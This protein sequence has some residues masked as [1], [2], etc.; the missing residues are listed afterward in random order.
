M[1]EPTKNLDE[2]V[3]K[4]WIPVEGLGL[5]EPSSVLRRRGVK[6]SQEGSRALSCLGVLLIVAAAF[7]S[8]VSVGTEVLAFKIL[9]IL[10]AGGAGLSLCLY[11]RLAEK[12][13][14]VDM[15]ERS[16]RFKGGA[17]V[18][19]DSVIGLQVCSKSFNPPLNANVENAILI[20]LAYQLNIAYLNADGAIERR[21]L[22]ADP[23]L[24]L[25]MDLAAGY[26]RLCSIRTLG[27]ESL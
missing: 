15:A 20:S 25:V 3:P 19:L 4:Y 11:R 22:L 7:I 1:T 26:R 14:L 21:C 13:V 27:Q 24:N 18:P 8:L 10:A 16:V 17:K 12:E 9:A 6:V 5:Q 23:S 2:R